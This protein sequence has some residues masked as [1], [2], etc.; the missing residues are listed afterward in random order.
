MAIENYL[1][2]SGIK[3][4]H[5]IYKEKLINRVTLLGRFIPLSAISVLAG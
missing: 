5:N 2:E 3:V 4:S 1:M